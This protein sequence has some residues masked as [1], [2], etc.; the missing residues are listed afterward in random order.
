MQRTKQKSSLADLIKQGSVWIAAGNSSKN[1]SVLEEAL[2]IEKRQLNDQLITVAAKSEKIATPFGIDAIDQSLPQG[3]LKS[4]AL[5]EWF[6]FPKDPRQF[7]GGKDWQFFFPWRNVAPCTVL[8]LLA[9]NAL[10]RSCKAINREI[11]PADRIIVW[12]GRNFWPAPYIFEQLF[13]SD[14]GS[15]SLLERCLFLNPP[16]CQLQFWCLEQALRSGAV[17]AVVAE[18]KG[19]R[20]ANSQ[21]LALAAR[22]S[23][24]LGLL[25]RHPK[26]LP[27]ASTAVSRWKVHP[28]PSPTRFPRWKLELLKNRAAPLQKNSW[29]IEFNYEERDKGFS[30]DLPAELVDRSDTKPEPQAASR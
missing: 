7:E 3:G 25:I 21:R 10:K 4:G 16:S 28:T 9:G 6:F 1:L 26:E 12:I 5:H 14:R 23:G 24:A 29:I 19:K 30:V 11:L 17:A 22:N 20:L 8:A 15:E 13:P 27:L 18:F 2:Q